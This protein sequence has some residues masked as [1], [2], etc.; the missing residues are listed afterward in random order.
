MRT[1]V[2]GTYAATLDTANADFSVV[3]FFGSV[4][5]GPPADDTVTAQ[6]K[7]EAAAHDSAVAGFSEAK[8]TVLLSFNGSVVQGK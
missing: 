6:F 1:L 5:A 4:C 2:N 7:F 3:A 8:V